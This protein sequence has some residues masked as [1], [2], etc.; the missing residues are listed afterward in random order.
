MALRLVPPALHGVISLTL[1]RQ[2]ILRTQ[3]VRSESQIGKTPGPPPSPLALGSSSVKGL[4]PRSS[5]GE[6]VHPWALPWAP[7][8]LRPSVDRARTHADPYRSHR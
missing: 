3:E 7:A 4:D 8:M 2:H 5:L 6:H 1:K